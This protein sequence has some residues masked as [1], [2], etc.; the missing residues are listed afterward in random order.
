[1]NK[2][3]YQRKLEFINQKNTPQ[4]TLAEI[5]KKKAVENELKRFWKKEATRWLEENRLHMPFDQWIANWHVIT[6]DYNLK[7][8][9][10]VIAKLYV[11]DF[12]WANGNT[13][14]MTEDPIRIPKK[15]LL[16]N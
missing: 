2:A 8:G 13:Q 14:T 7:A 16:V 3:T 4:T 10:T 15:E 5:K 6:F 9:G 11:A 1:M 12:S